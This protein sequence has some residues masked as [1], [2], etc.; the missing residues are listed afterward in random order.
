MTQHHSGFISSPI[1][2]IRIKASPV[3]VC[4]VEIL[5]S[6]GLD[7]KDLG[8]EGSTDS[9]SEVHIEGAKAALAAYF[10]QR[11]DIPEIVYDINGTDFQLAVWREIRKLKFGE[12]AT[13]G[14]I[15]ARIG[16]PK[17][18]RAVGAAVG[19]NPVPLLIGCHRV[20]GSA[21][22]ITGYSGGD[23]IATK[24]QLLRLEQIDFKE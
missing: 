23:G 6:T 17:A 11:F 10:S 7:A 5:P 14:E 19:A 20:L 2:T 13:Y 9:R 4:S 18:V 12:S 8:I 21:G 15:A 24:R 22:R 3:G 16:K 1:G